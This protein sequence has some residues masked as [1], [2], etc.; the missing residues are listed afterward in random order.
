MLGTLFRGIDETDKQSKLYVFVK[1]H[2]IKPGDELTGSSDIELISAK[3]RQA[4]EREEAKFQ[5]LDSVPGIKPSP[6]DPEK[7]LE[8]DEYIKQLREAAQ[9]DDPSKAKVSL[10]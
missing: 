2:I 4:F 8:D 7:I 10:D 6:M 1:A 9:R 3:K 5:G